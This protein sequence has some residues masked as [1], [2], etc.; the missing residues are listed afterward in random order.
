MDME[1]AFFLDRDGVIIEERNY[2]AD[3][4]QVVLCQGAAEAIRL[5]RD[6]GYL[7][8]VVS[9]QSGI[10]RGYFTQNQLAAVEH[11][12]DSLLAAGGTRVDAWYYCMHHKKGVVPEF[13]CECS[14][15]KPE[16][17]LFFQAAEDFNINLGESFMIGDKVS[18]IQA[19]EN[20]CCG[21]AVM[22]LTGHGSEERNQAEQQNIRIA[23][24]I[25]D[26]V[27]TLLN[28]TIQG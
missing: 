9:N 23:K 11:R 4:E 17:G 22:V 13:T 24:N 21:D 12:I 26:A 27:R 15:R 18:D 25:L 5:M 2:L 14:C 8:V 16:P 20:A 19:A 28:G 6:A 3:P 7:V 1:K 10:A